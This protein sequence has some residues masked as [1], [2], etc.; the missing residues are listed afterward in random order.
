MLDK[1]PDRLAKLGFDF[2]K[3]HCD[4]RLTIGRKTHT[5]AC[6][7][8]HW[9]ESEYPMPGHGGQYSLT[10]STASFTWLEENTLELTVR[11]LGEPFVVVIKVTFTEE[12]LTM[13]RKLNVNIGSTEQPPI[14]GH[15]EK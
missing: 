4:V 8:G 11:L 7:R 13:D 5:L 9:A 2:H 1:N 10:Q 14:K 12:G 15:L 3:G 6:G